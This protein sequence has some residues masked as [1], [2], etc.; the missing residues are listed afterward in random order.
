M[1]D[2]L[3]SIT[4]APVLA[5]P[6]DEMVLEESLTFP[7]KNILKELDG[8]HISERYIHTPSPRPMPLILPLPSQSLCRI[9]AAVIP[10]LKTTSFQV[11][12]Q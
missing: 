3:E 9:G 11:K 10:M 5:T 4:L 7:S 12:G 6:M 2:N 8:P 1:P